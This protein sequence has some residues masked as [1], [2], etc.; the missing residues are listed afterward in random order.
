MMT[1][2]AVVTDTNSGISVREAE[3]MGI[4][5]LPMPVVV[6]GREYT[7]GLDITHEELFTAMQEGKPVMTSQPSPEDV[8]ELWE[9]ALR[10]GAEQIVHVP[11]SSKLSGSCEAAMVLAGEFNGQV[12]VVDNHRISVTLR[13]S[14]LDAIY[15]AHQGKSAAEIKEQME[16]N[17]FDASIYICVHTLKYLK[18]SNRVTAAGAS[19]A[20]A[21]NL[22]PILNI[23][24][25]KLDAQC[26]V[27][28]EKHTQRTLIKL[29]EAD[30]EKRFRYIPR[31]EIRMYT[32]GTFT[33]PQ[34][35][36]EWTAKVQKNFKDTPVEY[37]PLS[38]SISCHV[39]ENAVAIAMAMK[40]EA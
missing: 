23:R 21:M 26:V 33:N 40:G 27:R 35:A 8:K 24:G 34:D 1:R 13:S 12:E 16:K 39:G 18:R 5:V 28:G 31:S 14:I 9:R 3:E 17:A 7:E 36:E 10:D 30:L 22:H 20:T 37:H 2:T 25:G 6:D 4:Y 15:L 11:M 38:C 19:L 29:M 32:A